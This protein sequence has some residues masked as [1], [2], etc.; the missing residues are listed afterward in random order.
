MFA[1]DIY[2]ICILQQE[3]H[4][5]KSPALTQCI[6]RGPAGFGVQTDQLPFDTLSTSKRVKALRVLC[7][8]LA[9][10]HKSGDEAEA[11]RLSRESYSE[12]RKAWERG[13]EE[14]LLGSTVTRF[15][16]GI[17]TLKLKEVVVDDSD[18]EAVTIGMT[19]CSKYSGHDPAKAA[20]LATPHPDDLRE[21]IQKLEDWRVSVESR[22]TE[23]RK[24]RK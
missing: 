17:S 23:T 14:V 11:T 8:N 6:G 9:K 13:V 4:L 20:L 16:E 22:K 2:F 7:D 1:H 19:K 24:R 5:A 15:D 12:L 18:Y 21:D 3:A 10:V